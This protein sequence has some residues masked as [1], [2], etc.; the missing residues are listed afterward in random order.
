MCRM[1]AF[2][3]GRE[4]KEFLISK[5]VAEAQRENVPLSE[6]ERK[7]LYFTESGWTLPDMEAISAEFDSEY[8]QAEYEKRVASLIQ[9]MGKQARKE[10]PAA[11]DTMLQA[12]RRLRTEDHYIVVMIRRAGLRPRGDL[13]RLWGTGVA[14]VIV[15]IPII[16]L[17][18]VLSDK[19]GIDLGRYLGRGGPLG[20]LIWVTAFCAL[21]A[22]QCLRSVLGAKRVDDWIFK[23]LL[24]VLRPR[25]RGA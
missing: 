23:V 12:I 6:V 18:V 15:L 22:Y 2:Q 20:P 4:A 13:L 9:K 3:S 8:D 10:S 5:I 7:M 21:I 24:K 25:I 1:V 19:Y 14:V 17:S 16:F 11:Y